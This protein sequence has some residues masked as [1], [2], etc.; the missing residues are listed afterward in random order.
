[1]LGEKYSKAK[2]TSIFNQKVL[3]ACYAGNTL[4]KKNINCQFK[5]TF[6]TKTNSNM[7]NSKVVFTF[8]VLDRKY[9]FWAIWSKKSKLS[10]LAEI[11]Y[12][13]LF[14]CAEFDCDFFFCFFF[15][16]SSEI[17]ILGKFGPKNQNCYCKLKF[18]T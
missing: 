17:I 7:Q 11:L 18:G 8:S 10:D 5:L 12:K 3:I 15:S 6:G 16:L 2:N 1:M 13:G 4:F 14:E 9:P